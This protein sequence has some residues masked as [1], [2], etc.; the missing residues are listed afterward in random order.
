MGKVED[1]E[2][3]GGNLFFETRD[4]AGAVVV[5]ETMVIEFA[6]VEAVLDGVGVAGLGTAAASGGDKRAP[7]G[8]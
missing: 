1:N 6:R 4:A 3:E 8:R 7:F 5:F 2:S